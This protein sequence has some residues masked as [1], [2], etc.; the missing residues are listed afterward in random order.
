MMHWLLQKLDQAECVPDM[1]IYV[2]GEV[3]WLQRTT[4][5]DLCTY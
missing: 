2:E 1:E 5:A 4:A 3:C